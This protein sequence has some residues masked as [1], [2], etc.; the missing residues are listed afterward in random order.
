M[1]KGQPSLSSIDI[2]ILC[3][4]TFRV[5][6]YSNLFHRASVFDCLNLSGFSFDLQSFTILRPTKALSNGLCEG[7]GRPGRDDEKH[8]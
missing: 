7:C 4:L 6:L 2:T 3:F 1:Q 5:N 8:S